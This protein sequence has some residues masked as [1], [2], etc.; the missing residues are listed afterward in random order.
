MTEGKGDVRGLMA[1]VIGQAVDDIRANKPQWNPPTD[2]EYA[3]YVSRQKK[4]G[5]RH[6]SRDDYEA[7]RL[8][9]YRNACIYWERTKEAASSWIN[10]ATND[11]L[12]SFRSISFVCLKKDLRVSPY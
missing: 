4:A 5:K 6:E 9:A 12:F 10:S 8:Y 11:H 7:K 3:S 2:Q 1:A